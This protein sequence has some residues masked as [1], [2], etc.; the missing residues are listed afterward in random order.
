MLV[1]EARARYFAENGFGDGGYDD[2]FV[3]L[4]VGGVP[5]LVFPNTKQRV[6]SVRIHDVH[7]VLTGYATSWRGEGEIARVGAGLRLPR[8]LG[9]LV[10]ELLGRADRPAHRAARDLARVPARAREPQPVRTGVGRWDPRSQR[11]RAAPRARPRCGALVARSSPAALGLGLALTACGRLEP[12][13]GCEGEGAV[14]V[15]CGFQNPED[16]ASAPG[17][18]WIVVSQFPRLVDGEISGS[19]SLLVLRPSDGERRILFPVPG[20]QLPAGVAGVG[21]AEC[22]GPPDPERFSPHGIDVAAAS[23]TAPRACSS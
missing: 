20:A 19:G 1:R 15:L 11:R 8:P 17:G 2:R 22:S 12:L 18:E 10:P 6:R 13:R 3:V 7:H 4:R 9:R 5:A 21:S 14:E 16:L 23:R